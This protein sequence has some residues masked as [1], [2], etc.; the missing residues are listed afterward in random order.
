[1]TWPEQ[2]NTWALWGFQ[3][4]QVWLIVGVV[5]NRFSAVTE[6]G[7]TTRDRKL[8]PGE[9]ERFLNLR[10]GL[11]SVPLCTEEHG[12]HGQSSFSQFQQYLKTR[13]VAVSQQTNETTTK[14]QHQQTMNWTAEKL[15]SLTVKTWPWRKRME[16]SATTGYIV[17]F[18]NAPKMAFH[19][20]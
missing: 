17:Y 9:L 5:V 19:S 1:M 8:F 16:A 13:V 4:L 10:A 14:Q 7:G 6:H 20:F 18:S 11:V 12:K 15:A 3:T 2:W